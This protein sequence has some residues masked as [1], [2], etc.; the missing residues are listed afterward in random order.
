[1]SVCS[2]CPTAASQ[3]LLKESNDVNRA[4][5]NFTHDE[6][7]LEPLAKAF[8]LLENGFSISVICRALQVNRSQFNRARAALDRV[9]PVGVQGWLQYLSVDQKKELK[10]WCVV[11]KY[12][13]RVPTLD[14]LR[15]K[16]RSAF[17]ILIFPLHV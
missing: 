7:A 15:M 11:E 4:I 10:E 2:V 6:N 9:T 16:V 3:D 14:A 5:A 17:Y 13:G 1:M 12:A 8:L